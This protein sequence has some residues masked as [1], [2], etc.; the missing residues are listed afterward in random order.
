MKEHTE[1]W[2]NLCEQAAVEQDPQ[3][4]LALTQKINDPLLGKQHRLEGETS[5]E[6]ADAQ[7]LKGPPRGVSIASQMSP[8]A[9]P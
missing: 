1:E 4:L 8:I 6:G 3:K 7:C 9:Q 2:K 5:T